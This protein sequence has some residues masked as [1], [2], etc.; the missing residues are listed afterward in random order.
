MFRISIVN[1]AKKIFDQHG[2][3]Y[4]SVDYKEDINIAKKLLIDK[5]GDHLWVTVGK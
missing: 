3:E 2:W 1:K 4:H 5:K